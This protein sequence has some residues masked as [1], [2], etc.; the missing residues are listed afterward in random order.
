[1]SETDSLLPVTTT[2]RQRKTQQVIAARSSIGDTLV[3]ETDGPQIS[4]YGHSHA[5]FASSLGF[6]EEYEE[7]VPRH[8]TWVHTAFL[9]LGDI[10]GTG[11]LSLA[12][13]F[14]GF[15]W[16]FGIILVVFFALANYHTGTML[17][18]LCLKHPTAHSY[19][20]RSRA[21]TSAGRS[22]ASAS[23]SSALREAS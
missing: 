11:V 12:A 1:M 18:R 2:T 3:E 22:R 14:A 16:I 4:K 8:S 15:G 23:R 21:T 5:S 20:S 13:A 19:R 9:L 6:G 7:G 17:H 10:V